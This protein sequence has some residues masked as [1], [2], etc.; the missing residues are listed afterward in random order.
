MVTTCVVAPVSSPAFFGAGDS[1][2]TESG[3][4]LIGEAQ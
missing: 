3:V 1:A 4:T 2:A